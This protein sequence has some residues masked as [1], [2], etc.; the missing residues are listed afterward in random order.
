M[1]FHISPFTLFIPT[2]FLSQKEVI[3]LVLM[4]IAFRI[5]KELF[6]VLF[7]VVVEHGHLL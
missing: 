3:L 6:C 2:K 4:T 5:G 7:C 1:L